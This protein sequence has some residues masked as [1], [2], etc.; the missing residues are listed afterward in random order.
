MKEFEATLPEK[1]FKRCEKR[2]SKKYEDW[3]KK[4]FES[5][6]VQETCV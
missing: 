6:D 3:I 2:A 1:D 4:E 5:H